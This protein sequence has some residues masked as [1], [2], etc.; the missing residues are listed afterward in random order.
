M[1]VSLGVGGVP[2]PAIA[3]GDITAV[4]AGAGITGGGSS[5]AVT[6]ALDVP[7]TVAR[8]G[9]NATDAATA[10]TNLGLGTA[11]TQAIAAFDAAGAAAAAQAASQPLDADLTAIAAANNSASLAKIGIAEAALT[12]TAGAL[13]WNPNTTPFAYHLQTENVTGITLT[14]PTARVPAVTIVLE[15]AGAFTWAN[16]WTGAVMNTGGAWVKPLTGQKN[17]YTLTPTLTA[18]G[19]A[20]WV[21]TSVTINL[22]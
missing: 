18:V 1:V 3:E 16:A 4:T 8:G 5:G 22:G 14:A 2:Y 9:T 7:V 20:V 6:V 15:G 13:A 11:A 10:R 12:T 21:L 17:A 19:A